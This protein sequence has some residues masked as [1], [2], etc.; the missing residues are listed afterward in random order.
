MEALERVRFAEWEGIGSAGASED[1]MTIARACQRGPTRR[2]T[3]EH[4][5][6]R[7]SS[8][9]LGARRALVAALIVAGGVWASAAHQASADSSTPTQSSLS[10]VSCVP[11]E[12]CVAVGQV[13]VGGEA[14]PLIES[15]QGRVWRTDQVASVGD[16][17]LL[18][19]VSCVVGGFCV[20][21]GSQP[22]QGALTE[23]L[24]AGGWTH[25]TVFS[26][27]GAASLGAVSCVSEDYCVAVGSTP[28]EQPL[29]ETWN[30]T[31][32]TLGDSRSSTRGGDGL[33]SGVS[34]VGVGNCVAVGTSFLRGKQTAL[35]AIEA[36]GIWQRL[37][38]RRVGSGT[39]LTGVSCV[40]PGWC[41]AVGSSQH[42]ATGVSDP[43]ALRITGETVA[44][45]VLPAAPAAS[46][47][48]VSCVGVHECVAVGDLPAAVQPT[49][50]HA[51]A[52]FAEALDR[53]GWSVLA[54][55]AEG[56]SYA[57]SGGVACVHAST[58]TAVGYEVG[59]ANA[60]ITTAAQRLTGSAWTPLVTPAGLG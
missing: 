6:V 48:G 29:V 19:G 52:P 23:V 24:L 25:E 56:S 43:L 40:L 35:V 15:L 42:A 30:G 59:A 2:T 11:D 60:Q 45:L 20:A 51:E 34:C 27:P 1:A 26:P 32:W 39:V 41:V 12:P 3:S 37:S 50:G 57:L 44:R 14:R 7:T 8:R 17:S 58:C 54:P 22:K 5:R 47:N 18:S 13:A 33:L 21:V 55:V 16:S 53:G 46:F 36:S 31:G 28:L 10:A 4:K 9:V 38:T 49:G